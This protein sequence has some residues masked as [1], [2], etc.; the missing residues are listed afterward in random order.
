MLYSTKENAEKA[1]ALR[2]LINKWRTSTETRSKADL[3]LDKNPILKQAAGS[4]KKI[5]PHT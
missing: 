4:S 5:T 1:R 3:L 2:K